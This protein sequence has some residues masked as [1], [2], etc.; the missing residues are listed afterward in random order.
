MAYSFL[1]NKFNG[2]CAIHL[3]P[4]GNCDIV[5][6]GNNS[7]SNLTSNGTSSEVISGAMIRRVIWSTDT[8]ILVKRGANT[9]IVLTQ[10]GDIRFDGLSVDL[11]PDAGI[12]VGTISANSFLIIEVDKKFSSVTSVY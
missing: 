8:S 5:V 3:A 10:T 6:V 2:K 11:F 1:W 12:N 9:V 4:A 7:V